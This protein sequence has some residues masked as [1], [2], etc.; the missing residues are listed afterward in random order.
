MAQ[1]VKDSLCLCCGVGSIL[2]P[3]TFTCHGCDQKKGGDGG[4]DREEGR[5]EVGGTAHCIWSGKVSSP[6]A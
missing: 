4:E 6:P 3:G 1:Q 5:E 2:G